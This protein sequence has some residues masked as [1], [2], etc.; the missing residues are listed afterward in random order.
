MHI[1]VFIFLSKC[2][3]ITFRLSIYSAYQI[4]LQVELGEKVKKKE[5]HINHSQVATANP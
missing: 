2:F 4:F 1:P 5:V 3:F